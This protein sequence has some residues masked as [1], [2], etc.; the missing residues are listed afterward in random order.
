MHTTKKDILVHDPSF[1]QYRTLGE[2]FPPESTCFM[3]SEPAYGCQ[4]S[5][6]K[7]SPQHKGRIQINLRQ[8]NEPDFTDIIQRKDRFALR[9]LPGY[10]AAQQLGISSH[11]LSRITGSIFVNTGSREAEPDR[12]SRVNIGLNMK[13]SKR[14][15]EVCGF[16]RKSPSD[17]NWMY[18]TS[19]IDNLHE[20]Y[21]KFPEV[22]D[23]LGRTDGNDI[24]HVSDIFTDEEE[25]SLIKEKLKKL[26]DW[27]K[28]L[29]CSNAARQP[30]G[31]QTLDENVI[32][33]IE[34]SLEEQKSDKGK[35][36][37]MQVKPHLLYKP[38][39]W[40]GNSMPDPETNFLLFDRVVNVREGFCVPLGCRGTVT[41]IQKSSSSEDNIYEVL[42]DKEFQGGMSIRS[43]N[44]RSY[45]VPGSALINFTFH[46]RFIKKPMAVV[47]PTMDSSASSWRQHN[48]NRNN[49]YNK[50]E[51]QPNRDKKM[52]KKKDESKAV[53]SGG[54][55]NPK[56]LP[57]PMAL[58]GKKSKKEDDQN[59]KDL[60]SAMETKEP[61]LNKDKNIC[62]DLKQMLN[63]GKDSPPQ[64]SPVPP[65]MVVNPSVQ[66]FFS[67]AAVAVPPQPISNCILLA[68]M[69]QPYGLCNYTHF[70]GM[71]IGQI[72][73]Q[74][75]C[76]TG[77]MF[78]SDL[79][80][81]TP[82]QA[83]EFAAG[84]ALAWF[85]LNGLPNIPNLRKPQ[86]KMRQKESKKD[87]QSSQS[88]KEKQPPPKTEHQ[89]VPL[90]VRVKQAKSATVESKPKKS[91]PQAEQTT[92][93][94]DKP[95]ETE[96][97]KPMKEESS[98]ANVVSVNTSKKP[99]NIKKK[100]RLA[101]NFGEEK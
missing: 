23:Y 97:N 4:G 94:V 73:A 56:N 44:G 77:Q 41:G 32:K 57:N 88:K 87:H 1:T 21:R 16:T 13:F 101:I 93:T 3:L 6:I 92:K 58:F 19:A 11:L 64:P 66:N 89:F 40:T 9:Y 8:I 10:R 42:F 72:F 91:I 20:Y 34:E 81:L 43:S 96:M 98:A 95:S 67:S 31:T 59:M 53:P 29:P 99:T 12:A 47:N 83:S 69:L 26:T 78:R 39:L 22:F 14:N 63:I 79:P 7:I 68:Q 15:E 46:K 48:T 2:L 85:N 30:C 50:P 86:E 51:S 71:Y 35:E 49:N 33:A 37:T 60:W 65:Q 90:Q 36:I 82:E 38:D 74:V 100:K 84:A 55:P 28:E 62:Q 5:V 54:P 70:P 25:L 80:S 75:Q 45:R 17:N 61:S 24:Y 27:I 18:S 52:L 76:P